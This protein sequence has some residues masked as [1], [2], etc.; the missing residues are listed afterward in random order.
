MGGQKRENDEEDAENG[1][2]GRRIHGDEHLPANIQPPEEQFP[3]ETTD[4]VKVILLGAPAVGKTSIIQQFVWNEFSDNYHPTNRRHTYYPS[5]VINGRLYDLKISD[6]PP[7]PYFPID[8]LLEWTDFRS[9][10]LRSATAYVL[11]FDLSNATETFRHL[12]CLREQMAN[13]RDMR[14]VPVVVVGNKHDRIH[15]PLGVGR[16]SVSSPFFPTQSSGFGLP[17]ASST[18]PCGSSLSSQVAAQYAPSHASSLLFNQ[19]QHQATA[20]AESRERRDIANIVKKH[21]RC[22]Y[23]EC[24][25]KYNWRVVAVFKELMK[26]IDSMEGRGNTGLSVLGSLGGNEPLVPG[27]SCGGRSKDSAAGFHLHRPHGAPVVVDNLHDSL[28][29]G[30]CDVL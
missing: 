20:L 28:D 6:L 10:G 1:R 2:E 9:F 19:Q 11:V 23:V 8:S 5:V 17:G 4:L 13:S 27:V 25:A 21:W 22:G 18:L 30:K 26:A 29:R 7:V 24:S 16:S 15:G 12:K 3:P 14:N